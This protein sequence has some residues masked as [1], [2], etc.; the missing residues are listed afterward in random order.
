MEFYKTTITELIA[1]GGV[2]PDLNVPVETGKCINIE[3]RRR[4]T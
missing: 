4:R 1:N 2:M 3:S